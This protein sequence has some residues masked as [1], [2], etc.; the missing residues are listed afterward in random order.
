[1]SWC[2]STSGC[3]PLVRR[4]GNKALEELAK[5]KVDSTVKQNEELGLKV[6][7]SKMIEF[8]YLF[9]AV[10]IESPYMRLIVMWRHLADQRTVR[11]QR[12]RSSPLTYARLAALASSHPLEHLVEERHEFGVQP[13][14]DLPVH[15][16]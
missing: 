1:M 16:R 13:L 3:L 5:K 6:H 14:Q 4:I 8:E 2:A 10:A 11:A 7:R 15:L 12:P 9:G